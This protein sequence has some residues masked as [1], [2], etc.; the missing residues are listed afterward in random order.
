MV[1]VCWVR[2]GMGLVDNVHEGQCQGVGR[3]TGDVGA[4]PQCKVIH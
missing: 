1:T 3:M 2:A 4:L